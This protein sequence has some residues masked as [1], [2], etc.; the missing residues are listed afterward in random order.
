[1]ARLKAAKPAAG[2]RANGLQEMD[3]LG[4]TISSKANLQKHKTQGRP[5]RHHVE[6]RARDSVPPR[7]NVS[8]D[9]S[10]KRSPRPPR[11]INKMTKT[12]AAMFAGRSYEPIAGWGPGGES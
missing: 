4:S 12:L 10:A 7:Q 6:L 8:D 5:H 3:R 9:H 11:E 1:M 2:E